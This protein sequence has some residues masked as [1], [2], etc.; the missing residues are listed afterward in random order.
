MN[1]RFVPQR[2]GVRWNFEAGRTMFR[3]RRTR[4]TFWLSHPDRLK[5]RPCHHG[6]LFGRNTRRRISI[7]RSSGTGQAR[8]NRLTH[9]RAESPMPCAITRWV[10]GRSRADVTAFRSGTSRMGGSLSTSKMPARNW[11]FHRG[12]AGDGYVPSDG[13]LHRSEKHQRRPLRTTG[14]RANRWYRTRRAVNPAR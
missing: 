6:G 1:G 7:R 12:D 14:A 2:R 3:P 11:R 8:R 4:S 9:Q 10:T 5:G 13:L